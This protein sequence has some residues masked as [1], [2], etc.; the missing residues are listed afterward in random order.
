MGKPT[1]VPG[2]N[3]QWPWS[4]LILDQTKT[5]ETRGY[6]IPLKYIGIPLAVIE[7][8]GPNGKANGV[9]K[10]RIAGIVIFESC[11]QYRTKAEWAKD[12][13]LHKV[14][15]DHPQFRFEAGKPKWGWRVKSAKKIEPRPAPQ[16]R[17]IVFT[18]HC[19]I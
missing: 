3:I 17:G 14:A 18:G 11:F 7:T 12:Q 8:P 9:V 6:P 19:E 4:Q 10:A 15:A 2:L 1:L 13:P 5:I 16:K